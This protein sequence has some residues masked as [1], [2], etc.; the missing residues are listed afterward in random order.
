MDSRSPTQLQL[1]NQFNEK[2][3]IQVFKQGLQAKIQDKMQ[4]LLLEGTIQKKQM[5]KSQ[6]KQKQ[7]TKSPSS[8]TSDPEDKRYGHF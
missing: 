8:D 4:E 6:K 7:A 1:T 5:D 2:S 3:M